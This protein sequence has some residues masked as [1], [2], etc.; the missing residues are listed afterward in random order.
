MRPLIPLAL[1]S[2]L[3]AATAAHANTLAITP[4]SPDETQRFTIR[5]SGVAESACVP[6]DPRMSIEGRTIVIRY[7]ITIEICT[8]VQTPYASELTVGPLPAGLYTVLAIFGSG[9]E[10]LDEAAL[11]VRPVAMPFR[12]FPHAVP[13]TTGGVVEI[14]G[15]RGAFCESGIPNCTRREVLFGDRSVTVEVNDFALSFM[16]NA[17]PQ[18][19]DVVNV[20]V[21]YP[22]GTS[23]TAPAA[24]RY[25]DPAAPPD[26]ALFKRI[27]LPVTRDV[28]GAFGSDFRVSVAVFNENR[29]PVPLWR[30]VGET[31][32]LPPFAQTRLSSDKANGVFILPL[33]TAADAL[34]FA[35]NARDVSRVRETFG[36]EVRVVHEEDA[37]VG[38]SEL[39]NVPADPNFRIGLRV[40][41]MESVN[42]RVHV[43]LHST[44][45]R[46][47]Y[48]DMDLELRAPSPEEPPF[49]FIGDLRAAFPGLESASGS[50]RVRLQGAFGYRYWALLTVTNNTTQQITT[51]TPQ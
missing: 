42:D 44:D 50:Y 7:R 13:K 23:S 16:V 11:E 49:A 47:F 8:S 3:L 41:G 48:G 34:Y 2:L 10:T 45:S 6:S 39:L 19:V 46:I 33:R 15:A 4:A 26:P 20:T 17:P 25:Y 22:N 14:R 40:Y 43:S 21:R 31:A 29:Y 5:L 37:R 1:V 24:L 12:L 9:N 28:Q 38:V 30:P 32:A 27:L 35:S 18:N 51:M 36:S